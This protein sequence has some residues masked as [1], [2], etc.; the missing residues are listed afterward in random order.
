MEEKVKGQIVKIQTTA[1][2]CVRIVVDIPNELAPAD[3]IKW[4]NSTV[5]I[6]I[7]ERVE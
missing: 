5:S 1:D 2:Q 4:L 3:I 7:V 6:Q